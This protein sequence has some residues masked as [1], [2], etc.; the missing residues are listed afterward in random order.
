MKVWNLTAD[1]DGYES[2]KFKNEEK[3]FLRNFKNE[4]SKG[5]KIKGK[6]DNFELEIIDTGES[7]DLP[8]FWNYIGT[9]VF[10]ERAKKCLEA[11]LEDCV[12]FIPVKYEQINY[13]MLNVVR[14]ADAIDYD[15]A[16]FRKLDT[17]LV[18]GMDKYA[19]K[20]D[21]IKNINMFKVLLNGRI[22]DSEIYIS[23]ELKEKIEEFNLKG[24]KFTEMWDSD[25]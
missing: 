4:M 23:S 19:F 3:D 24:F 17:G 1:M 18:V 22:Y 13:Y 11:Y 7:S 9:L 2:F 5:E 21:V 25:K 10:S 14:I 6:F 15:C 8:R 16:T 20:K 12:E